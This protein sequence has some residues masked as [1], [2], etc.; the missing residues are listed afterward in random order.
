MLAFL[1]ALVS[2]SSWAQQPV[3]LELVLA[4]DTSTSVD[5]EEYVLQRQGVVEASRSR[6][7]F[8][9]EWSQADNK[10]S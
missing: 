9:P 4:I 5:E 8:F 6:F 1:L 2:P 3:E 7:P 10:T